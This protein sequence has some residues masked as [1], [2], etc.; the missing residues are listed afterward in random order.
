VQHIPNCLDVR[1]T[2]RTTM[3]SYNY[4]LQT[5]AS[6]LVNDIFPAGRCTG[7]V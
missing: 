5:C 6:N 3:A 4:W 1:Q 7:I 2:A